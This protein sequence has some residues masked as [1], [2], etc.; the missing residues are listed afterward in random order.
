[1]FDYEDDGDIDSYDNIY[2]KLYLWD[3]KNEDGVCSINEVQV[4]KILI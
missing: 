2:E 3:D 1:M 4:Y